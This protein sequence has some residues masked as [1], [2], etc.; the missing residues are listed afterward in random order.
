MKTLS[1]LDPFTIAIAAVVAAA[2][3]VPCRGVVATGC[4]LCANTLVSALFFFHGARLSREST[5]RAITNYR[6]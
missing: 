2:T 4:D 1:K 3:L 6:L 5:R